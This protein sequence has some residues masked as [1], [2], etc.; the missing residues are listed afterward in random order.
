MAS[1]PTSVIGGQP[2]NPAQDRLYTIAIS[3][4][5]AGGGDQ[6][7]FFKALKPRGTGVLLRTAIIDHIRDLTKA[8]Q[9]G[10]GR[11]PKAA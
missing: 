11:K 1:P 5:L 9:A 4:Y 3:D 8:G 10:R 7:T 6:L 2:F